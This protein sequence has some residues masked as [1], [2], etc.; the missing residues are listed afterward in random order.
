MKPSSSTEPVDP[1]GQ[2]SAPAAQTEANLESV[3][4]RGQN[5]RKGATFGERLTTLRKRHG[6]TQEEVAFRSGLHVAAVC[7]FER[8]RRSPS[9]RNIQRLCSA[10]NVSPN[11]LIPPLPIKVTKLPAGRVEELWRSG[12]ACVDRGER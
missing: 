2:D 9:L 4:V 5:A 1:K 6:L 11:L 8:N 12:A 10:L 3:E 7:H